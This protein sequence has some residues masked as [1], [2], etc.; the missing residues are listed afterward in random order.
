MGPKQTETTFENEPTLVQIVDSDDD[1]EEVV[2][3]INRSEVSNEDECAM[4][5]G[6]GSSDAGDSDKELENHAGQA[7][8]LPNEDNFSI[9]AVDGAST[10]GDLS[11]QTSIDENPVPCNSPSP[12]IEHEQEASPPTSPQV[13][14]AHSS[15]E[16]KQPDPSDVQQLSTLAERCGASFIRQPVVRVGSPKLPEIPQIDATRSSEEAILPDSFDIGPQRTLAEHGRAS[17]AYQPVVSTGTPKPLETIDPRKDI[18]NGDKNDQPPKTDSAIGTPLRTENRAQTT[19]EDWTKPGMAPS[20]LGRDPDWASMRSRHNAILSQA[21]QGLAPSGPGLDPAGFWD[22]H[23][24]GSTAGKA[25]TRGQPPVVGSFARSLHRGSS[26]S[27]THLSPYPHARRNPYYTQGPFAPPVSQM[28]MPSNNPMD[29]APQTPPP[30]TNF[31]PFDFD[32]SVDASDRAGACNAHN[33]PP[34]A[35]GYSGRGLPNE[36]IASRNALFS[37]RLGNMLDRMHSIHD[38]NVNAATSKSRPL[39]V[40]RSDP[41]TIVQE[42]GENSLKRKH[43]EIEAQVEVKP[44]EKQDER[45]SDVPGLVVSSTAAPTRENTGNNKSEP[46]VQPT[47]AQQ[48]VAKAA[49]G[50]TSKELAEDMEDR[51]CK[52]VKTTHAASNMTRYAATALAGVVVGGI[53]TV[54]ALAAL[55]AGFFE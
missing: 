15:E 36:N 9:R 32:A 33:C 30:S 4:T 35:G 50:T 18:V 41:R 28:P 48:I 54:M 2:S 27:P 5:S 13:D 31:G 45:V 38:A 25:V 23:L 29:H 44:V 49:E 1:D 21:H 34:P 52:R 43:N 14:D 17:L 16:E 19:E 24:I 8:E 22:R 12:E 7:V 20:L 39:S 55:P 3:E 26:T 37:A 53:G 11:E 42:G 51:P 46:S 40:S 6:D 47:A 10:Q